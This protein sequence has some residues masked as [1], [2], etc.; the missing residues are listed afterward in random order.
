MNES[1]D[2]VWKALAD[3]TRREVLDALRDGPRTTTE[4]VE[5]F[6]KLSRFAVMKHIDVLRDAGLITTRPE[7][8]RRIHAINVVPIRMIY[9]R[10]VHRFEDLWAT[11]LTALKRSAESAARKKKKP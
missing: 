2:V 1:L 10:W 7:G 9:E 5:L 8:R 4:L 11:K 3:K 6:P